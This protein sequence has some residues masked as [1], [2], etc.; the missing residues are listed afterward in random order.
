MT[1]KSLARI[2]IVGDFMK[3]LG[4][5]DFEG[6]GKHLADNAKMVLPYFE[7]MPPLDGK[8]AML[9]QMKATMTQMFER[10]EFIFDAWYPVEGQDALVAEYHSVCPRLG[11][12]GTYENSYITL[13]R[14]E[15]DKI[16]LYK[17]YL[18]PTKLNFA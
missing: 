2:E 5:F 7:A 3:K 4:A 16:T 6:A 11:N 9:K 14:F 1:P 13:Y 8:A 17:E 15:G 10:M 12:A 18:N